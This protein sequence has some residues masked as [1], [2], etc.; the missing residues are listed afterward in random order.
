MDTDGWAH[1]SKDFVKHRDR[2]WLCWLDSSVL[3][4]SVLFFGSELHQ[5][6]NNC[7]RAGPFQQVLSRFGQRTTQLLGGDAHLPCLAQSCWG[8]LLWLR[9]QPVRTE[10]L[11]TN[12]EVWTHGSMIHYFWVHTVNAGARFFFLDPYFP[13]SD[14]RELIGYHGSTFFFQFHMQNYGKIG[15]M[16]SNECQQALIGHHGSMSNV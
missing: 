10:P 7:T 6:G 16:V 12:W 15:S 4:R 3:F 5:H 8:T 11:G 1:F 14:Q 2:L 13:I 9:L